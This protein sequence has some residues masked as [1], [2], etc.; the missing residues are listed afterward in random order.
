MPSTTNGSVKI[1]FPA[2]WIAVFAVPLLGL[3]SLQAYSAGSQADVVERAILVH[4][5]DRHKDAASTADMQ[6]VQYVQES[7]GEDVVDLK[8]MVKEL[9]SMHQELIVELRT[10][11]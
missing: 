3:G 11:R 9:A 4:G 6:H 8:Q 2:R 10:M 1:S 7:L 5:Q